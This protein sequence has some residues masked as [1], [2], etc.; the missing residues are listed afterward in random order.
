MN[1]FLKF[2]LNVHG[3]L[4]KWQRYQSVSA[5]LVQGGALWGLKGKAGLLDDVNVTVDTKHQFASHAPFGS[6]DVRSSFEQNRIALEKTDGTILAEDLS[7]RRSFEGHTLQTPWNDLQLAFFAGC[8]M[9][10]YLNVPF[11]LASPGVEVTEVSPWNE[12]GETW[13]RFDVT[14]PQTLEVFSRNQT[15]Y[16]GEDGLLRRM[17]YD[18]EIAGNTPGAHYVSEYREF[19]GIMFPTKR[20]I[21]PRQPDG[22]SFSEPLV[23]SIA[24]DSIVLREG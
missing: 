18:V 10:T 19:S 13:R 7:P 20:E 16:F 17:D 9:W 12:R 2:V 3:G 6:P 8:A 11:V 5:H 14:Y 15:V 21:F 4:E 1:D 24:L 22:T 23:V